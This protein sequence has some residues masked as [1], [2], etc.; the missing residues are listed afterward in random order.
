M[1]RPDV[2]VL[3]DCDVQNILV[4]YAIMAGV[5]AVAIHFMGSWHGALHAS[6]NAVALAI[7][8]LYIAAVVVATTEV[9]PGGRK[10]K[11]WWIIAAFVPT[12]DF[13]GFFIPVGLLISWGFL[14]D[15]YWQIARAGQPRQG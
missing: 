13:A 7:G 6:C 14:L 9:L 2:S 5:T 12:W 11:I 4:A 10:Q 3:K 1:G 15:R 8:F